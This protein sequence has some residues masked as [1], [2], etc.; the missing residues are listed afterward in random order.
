[1]LWD[2]DGANARVPRLGLPFAV[3]GL[4]AGW[5]S[6]RAVSSPLFDPPARGI[7]FE[8]T[9]VTA[10]C[11]GAVLGI[12]CRRWCRRSLSFAGPPIPWHLVFILVELIGAGTGA[13]VSA[14]AHRHRAWLEGTAIGLGCAVPVFPV[15]AVVI[16]AAQ[17]AARARLGSIVAAADRRTVWAML[18]AGLAPLTVPAVAEWLPGRRYLIFPPVLE[19]AIALVAFLVVTG[20]VVFDLAARARLRRMVGSL[21]ALEPIADVDGAP[22]AIRRTD[23]GLGR[24]ARARVHVPEHYRRGPEVR[25]LVIGEPEEADRALASIVR[26][27]GIRF[28]LAALVLGAHAVAPLLLR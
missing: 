2:E 15:V 14:N 8:R 9:A 24:G 7:S 28:V 6:A 21:G 12:L 11:A 27:G 17:R 16:A 22:R 4:A 1:V 13:F 18:F 5:L 10:A 26:H 25:A 20:C 19:I 3:V 23:V